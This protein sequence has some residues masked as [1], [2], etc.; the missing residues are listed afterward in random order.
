MPTPT[1]IARFSRSVVRGGRHVAEPTLM[2]TQAFF[3][4]ICSAARF[5]LRRPLDIHTQDVA[6]EPVDDVVRV[7]RVDDVDVAAVDATDWSSFVLASTQ[8]KVQR[9]GGGGG[10]E[11]GCCHTHGSSPRRA[12]WSRASCLTHG[13]YRWSTNMD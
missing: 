6:V 1:Q 12:L 4:A 11:V 2:T 13:M 10:G 3:D 9:A 5:S 8:P 7:P